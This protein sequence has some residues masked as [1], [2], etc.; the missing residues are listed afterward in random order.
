MVGRLYKFP[1]WCKRPIIFRGRKK[2]L[3]WFSQ[4]SFNR[5]LIGKSGCQ[6]S[7]ALL[8]WPKT[9]PK[10]L[11]SGTSLRLPR[12]DLGMQDAH[13]PKNFWLCFTS[14]IFPTRNQRK[15]RN[16]WLNDDIY[17]EWP[18]VWAVVMGIKTLLVPKSRY[19]CWIRTSH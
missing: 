19:S 1:F 18:K 14:N 13:R 2:C 9:R 17:F 5:S 3:C 8:P 6:S 10:P 16:V 4:A 11:T 12:S 7:Q 15:W